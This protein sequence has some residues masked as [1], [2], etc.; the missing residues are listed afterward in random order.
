MGSEGIE[1]MLMRLM[2]FCA[3]CCVV[4]VVGCSRSERPAG[5]AG[6]AATG[7]VVAVKEK[8]EVVATNTSALSATSA[9]HSS[10]NR[11]TNKPNPVTMKA[12]QDRRSEFTKKRVAEELKRIEADLEV[13]TGQISAMEL[14]LI[15]TNSVIKEAAIA[16]DRARQNYEQTWMA[17]PEMKELFQK[18]EA[19]KQRIASLR[20]R[21]GAA[22][23]K[24][25]DEANAECFQLMR[26]MNELAPVGR[27]NSIAMAEAFVNMQK[28]EAT[29]AASMMAIPERV[30]LYKKQQTLMDEFEKLSKRQLDLV[31]EKK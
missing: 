7:S 27:T 2:K 1:K 10:T 4:A 12:M 31:K 11:P 9:T 22:V 20:G 24:D 19:V 14:G 8:G 17:L 16:Q 15:Q 3:W 25:L 21:E 23:G 30:E 6:A 26:Q 28:A 5:G 18:R 13:V 29:Y